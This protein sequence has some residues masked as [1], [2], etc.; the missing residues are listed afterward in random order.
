MTLL[1]SLLAKRSQLLAVARQHGATNLRLFGSVVHGEETPSSDVDVLID[2]ADDRGFEDYLALAEAL[3]ALVGR[4]VDL[5]T[6][7]GLSPFLRPRIES[8]A[9]AL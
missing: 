5:V 7:R 2:L 3:E 9:V 8:E 6:S 4:K 1:E